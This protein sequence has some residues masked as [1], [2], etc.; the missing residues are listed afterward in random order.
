MNVCMGACQY[1]CRYLQWAEVLD[2][3]NIELGKL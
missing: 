1:E 3:L 2:L